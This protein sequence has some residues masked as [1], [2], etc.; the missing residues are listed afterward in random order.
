MKGLSET[1]VSGEKRPSVLVTIPAF[2]EAKR[3]P[4]FLDTLLSALS[5]LEDAVQLHVQVV[6]DGS[7]PEERA[8]C[9][10]EVCQREGQ[11]PG[12][13][14]TFL[15]L[16][17]NVGKGGAILAGW[18]A[19]P[20]ADFYLFVDSDGAVPA[21]EVARLLSEAVRREEPVL[22]FASRVKMLG[23]SVQRT[24]LRHCTGRLFA[25]F[26]GCYINSNIYDSQ[27]GLKIVPGAHRKRIDRYLQGNRFAFDVELLA[28]ASSQ[29]LKMEE[30][31]IDWFDVP[32]SKVSLIRDTVRMIKSV[33]VIRRLMNTGYYTR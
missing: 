5:A 22:I 29:G 10:A 17:Q 32:G 1:P 24:A 23:K 33:W 31:P 28:A 19:V 25:F 21:A 6:D 30:A 18:R 7:A 15:E 14:L 20:E 4:R 3:L 2:N 12:L 8:R 16:P 27:C 13:S 26:V 11:H 9:R